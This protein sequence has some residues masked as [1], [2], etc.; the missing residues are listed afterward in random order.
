MAEHFIGVEH[1]LLITQMVREMDDP[2]AIVAELD[3]RVEEELE[4][5]KKERGKGRHRK[6]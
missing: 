4:R 6:R 5:L 2:L 1:L 3:C